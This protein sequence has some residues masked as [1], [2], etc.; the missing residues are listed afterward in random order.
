MAPSLGMIWCLRNDLVESTTN[1]SAV[2]ST[3]GVAG[4]DPLSL[5]MAVVPDGKNAQD[6]ADL[7]LPTGTFTAQ[8]TNFLLKLLMDAIP[9][10]PLAD[11][12]ELTSIRTPPDDL[13]AQLDGAVTL[14]YTVS[15]FDVA[16]GEQWAA[17]NTPFPRLERYSSWHKVRSLLNTGS[18]LPQHQS[19]S[20][21]AGVTTGTSHTT[22]VESGISITAEVG[23]EF[24]GVNAGVSVTV[25][26]QF[27]SSD[28]SSRDE[29][30]EQ[31][32]TIDLDVPPNSLG[33][34]WVQQWSFHL[35][36]GTLPVI[37]L[38]T[39]MTRHSVIQ[40]Y[41]LPAMAAAAAASA[42]GTAN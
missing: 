19:D 24:A 35:C 7:W 2:W 11:P 27:G 15:G 23:V 32:V 6:T 12:P 42:G 13:P 1:V 10:N 29:M 30:K 20:V 18:D 36:R 40:V 34:S 22:S 28:T 16:K 3:A 31:N 17:E 25:N 21:S 8:G 38:P 41:T 4:G 37:T 14:P 5:F 33:V 39:I 26:Q 9:P